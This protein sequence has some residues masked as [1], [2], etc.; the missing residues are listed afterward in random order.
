MYYSEDPNR[1]VK[2]IARITDK[3]IVRLRDKNKIELFTHLFKEYGFKEEKVLREK[4]WEK[5]DR[6]TDD[7]YL[8]F[9]TK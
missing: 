2:E 1:L 6:Q 3:V 7:F 4:W 9:F 8:Y 5:L